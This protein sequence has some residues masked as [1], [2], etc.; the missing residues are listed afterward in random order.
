[1]A[2]VVVERTVLLHEHDDVFDIAD[3]AGARKRGHGK[4]IANGLGQRGQRG[5]SAGR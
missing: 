4:R 3:R 5:S 1:M 2:E